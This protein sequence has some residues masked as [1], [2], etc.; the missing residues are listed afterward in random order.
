[1]EAQDSALRNPTGSSGADDGHGTGPT[2]GV[3]IS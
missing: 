2:A 1:M 3:L